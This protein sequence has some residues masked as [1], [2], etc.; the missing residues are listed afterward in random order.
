MTEFDHFKDLIDSFEALLTEELR[1]YRQ[2]VNENIRDFEALLLRFAENWNNVKPQNIVFSDVDAVDS[3]VKLLTAQRTNL[4]DLQKQEQKIQEELEF[5]SMETRK[6]PQIEEVGKEVTQYFDNFNLIA[7]FNEQFEKLFV[8]DW[9]VVRASLFEFEDLINIWTKRLN[10]MREEMLENMETTNTLSNSGFN[11]VFQFLFNEN[12]KNYRDV[13]PILKL[14][15]GENFTTTHWSELLVI[16]SIK[17]KKFKDVTFK[18]LIDCVKVFFEKEKEIRVLYNRAQGE[19]MIRDALQELDSWGTSQTFELAE[20]TNEMLSTNI[21]KDWNDLFTVVS[22]NQALLNSLKE[23][24]Y[25]PNFEAQILFWEAKIEAIVRLLQN[26]NNI[27]RK[28]VYLNPIFLRGSIPKEKKKFKQLNDEI[29]VFFKYFTVNPAIFD[30][31]RFNKLERPDQSLSLSVKSLSERSL[32]IFTFTNNTVKALEVFQKKLFDFLEEKREIFPRFYF[33][34]D[35]DLLEVL[36]QSQNIE[37]LQTHMKKLFSGIS[38]IVVEAEIDEVDNSEQKKIIEIISSTDEH[39]LLNKP[40]WI[41]RGRNTEHLTANLDESGST[42]EGLKTYLPVE[43]W[44]NE[45]E[46]VVS[47]TLKELTYECVQQIDLENYPI[48]SILLSYSVAFTKAVEK[49]ME[50]PDISSRKSKLEKYKEEISIGM[51]QYIAVTETCEPLLRMNIK[52]LIFDLVHQLDILQELIEHPDPTAKCFLWNRQLRFYVDKDKTVYCECCDAKFPY[53]Y[54]YLSHTPK[55]VHTPLTDKLYL[56]LTQGLMFGY[57]GNPVGPAGTGKTE[58]VKQLASIMGLMCIVLNCDEG[59]DYRSMGRIF[60]GLVK[61]GA[62]GCFD[63]FNRLDEEVLSAIS[64]QISAI[65]N[66]IK[67]KSPFTELLGKQ[68]PT[69]PAT[70]IFV[71]MNPLSKEYQGR[72]LLPDNLKALFR[73][74]KMIKPSLHKIIQN[75]L[76]LE[77]Y[78]LEYLPSLTARTVFFF[79][80]VSNQL[81]PQNHYDWGLRSL[82][83]IIAMAGR[84][85]RNRKTKMKQRLLEEDPELANMTDED[86]RDKIQISEQEQSDLIVQAI[87]MSTVAKLTAD[88][89]KTFDQLLRDIFPNVGDEQKLTSNE[90]IEMVLNEYTFDKLGLTKS[91]AQVHKVLQ[92]WN[93]VTQRMGVCIVGPSLSGKTTVWKLLTETLRFCGI[94]CHIDV[95]SPKSMPRQ[96]LLGNMDLDTREWEDGVLTAS[97]RRAQ[98]RIASLS[99]LPF[100]SDVIE[101]LDVEA[102]VL[103]FKDKGE[104]PKSRPTI[105]FCT[106]VIC[107]GDI[108]PEWIES[109]NSVLDD[110][111]LLTLPSGE[112]IK[113]DRSVN[114]LFETES[115]LYASPATVSRM[116]MVFLSELDNDL[117]A[118]ATTLIKEAKDLRNPVELQDWLENILIPVIIDYTKNHE[119]AFMLPCTPGGLMRAIFPHVRNCTDQQEFLVG[120][121]LGL[122]PSLIPEARDDFIKT[123]FQQNKFHTR[124][125]DPQNPLNMS[126][127]TDSRSIEDLAMAWDVNE[128]EPLDV[129]E[130]NCLRRVPTSHM[131]SYENVLLTWLWNEFDKGDDAISSATLLIGQPASGKNTLFGNV[132]SSIKK[133]MKENGRSLHLYTLTCSRFTQTADI[134]EIIKSNTDEVIQG[135]DLILM[136]ARNSQMVIYLKN[137]FQLHFDQYGTSEVNEFLFSLLSLGG[138]YDSKTNEFVHIKNISFVFSSDLGMMGGDSKKLIS[139]RLASC[140]NICYLHFPSKEE[141]EVVGNE[142]IKQSVHMEE[143]FMQQLV[144]AS[145]ELYFRLNK[146]LQDQNTK[147]PDYF[148]FNPRDLISLL[149][150]LDRY[151]LI[152]TDFIVDKMMLEREAKKEGKS[153]EAKQLLADQIKKASNMDK[154]QCL[155]NAWFNESVV[156]FE[157]RLTT[158]M[159][160]HRFLTI[161]TNVFQNRFHSYDV[162]SINEILFTSVA[163]YLKE[164]IV[165]S[166][167]TG[168]V[169][170]QT[171]TQT[172]LANKKLIQ[173]SRGNLKGLLNYY[174]KQ[175]YREV[176]ESPIFVTKELLNIFSKIDRHFCHHKDQSLI[177]LTPPG[178][179]RTTAWSLYCFIKQV[180]LYTP[181]YMRGL[182]LKYFRNELKQQIVTNFIQNNNELIIKLDDNHLH[183]VSIV[184]YISS[185]ISGVSVTKLFNPEELEGVSM[186]LKEEMRNEGY[187]G[188]L[189]N[190]IDERVRKNLKF[191]FCLDFRGNDFSNKVNTFSALY[192]NSAILVLE[193]W[194]DNTLMTLFKQEVFGDLLKKMKEKNVTS[195]IYELIG[196]ENDSVVEIQNDMSALFLSLYHSI[197]TFEKFSQTT[198]FAYESFA[199]TIRVYDAQSKNEESQTF[200]EKVEIPAISPTHFIKCITNMKSLLAKHWVDVED[201]MTRLGLGLSKL[202]ETEVQVG[203]MQKDAAEQSKILSQKQEEAATALEQIKINM[204]LA[205]EQ[206]AAAEKLSTY[207]NGEEAKINAEKEVAEAQLSSI[208]PLI[209]AA[210]EN[211]DCIEPKHLNEIRSFA[212]PPAA[213]QDVLQGVMMMLGFNNLSWKDIKGM[214]NPSIKERIFKFDSR[215]VTPNQLKKIARF[216]ETNDSSFESDNIRRVSQAAAPMAE[217]LKAQV[218]YAKV[219][220]NIKP[221]TDNLAKL[222]ASLEDSRIQLRECQEKIVEADEK[223]AALTE[224]FSKKTGEA[225]RLKVNLEKQTSLLNRAQEL[226][227]KLSGE[228]ARWEKQYQ[229]FELSKSN[230]F[231]S[232]MVSSCYFTYLSQSNLKTRSYFLKMWTEALGFENKMQE[233]FCIQDFLLKEST[234]LSL[235]LLGLLS[236]RLSLENYLSFANTDGVPCLID[237]TGSI[238]AFIVALLENPLED[239]MKPQYDVVSA[240]DTSLLTKLELA[241]RFGKTLILKDV[242]TI[243]TVLTPLLK[244]IVVEQNQR[245]RTLVGEKSIDLHDDFKLILLTQNPK[246]LQTLPDFAKDYITMINFSITFNGLMSQIIEIVVENEQPE[247]QEEKVELLKDEETLKATLAKLENELLQNLQ[248]DKPLLE[249]EELIENLNLMKVKSAEITVSLERCDLVKANLEEQKQVFTNFSKTTSILYFL[250][251]NLFSLNHV[252]QFSLQSFFRLFKNT[253]KEKSG[254]DATGDRA[255]L[256]HARLQFL[257]TVLLT[258]VYNYLSAG[259]FKVDRPLFAF[260]I[261]YGLYSDAFPPNLYDFIT[262]QCIF[263]QTLK[264]SLSKAKIPSF[265]NDSM[266]LQLDKL[267]AV[268]PK[269]SDIWNNIISDQSHWT[270]WMVSQNPEDSGNAFFNN[271]GPVERISIVKILRPDR[272]PISIQKFVFGKL[273]LTSFEPALIDFKLLIERDSYPQQFIIYLVN[274]GMDPSDE[275]KSKLENYWT[276]RGKENF[277]DHFAEVSMG[278]GQQPV[279]LAAIEKMMKNGGFVILKNLHLVVRWIP[280]LQQYFHQCAP[281]SFHPDFRIFVT[282]EPR[283]TIPSSLLDNA[284]KITYEAPPGIRQNLF[285]LY[286]SL[287]T[288]EMLINC[289]PIVSR[290]IFLVC[291]LH[292]LLQ[293]R[294]TYNP[295]GWT[296]TYEFNMSNLKST[297]DTIIHFCDFMLDN[298]KALNKRPT[299]NHTTKISAIPWKTLRG[300]VTESIYGG[301]LDNDQDYYI[302]KAYVENTIDE[303]VLSGEKPFLKSMPHLRVPSSTNISDYQNIIAQLPSND[304]PIMFGLSP[305]VDRFI[306]VTEADRLITGLQTLARGGID[307]GSGDASLNIAGLKTALEPTLRIWNGLRKNNPTNAPSI[308]PVTPLDSLVYQQ[309][310]TSVSLFNLVD[311]DFKQIQKVFDG[312]SVLTAAL[313]NVI[314]YLAKGDVPRAWTKRWWGPEGINKWMDSFIAKATMLKQYVNRIHSHLSGNNDSCGLLTGAVELHAFLQPASFLKALHQTAARG[315]G[316][317]VEELHFRTSWT[318]PDISVYA[319]LTNLYIQGGLFTSKDVTDCL[320]TSAATSSLN[321]CY[322]YFTTDIEEDSN[323][324]QVP[325]YT[326]ITREEYLFNVIMP[327]SVPADKWHLAGLAVLLINKT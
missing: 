202:R 108:D 146:E 287:V 194:S 2:K 136:P 318:Q 26:I 61:C 57:G 255:L 75:L 86:I 29:L 23:S 182:N 278:Q 308:D 244:G 174:I 5:F 31:L 204:A 263:D 322:L 298:P 88:D 141:I 160:K 21:I 284:T 311:G 132:I 259:I 280:D 190:Y 63:E 109:L 10:D 66:S 293:E 153:E 138:F 303:K 189:V 54:E 205:N 69:N 100:A 58:S 183:D 246:L 290:L 149:L 47:E 304:T 236:D 59:I 192:Q 64:T 7:E 3:T 233:P 133:D 50:S 272:L 84:L 157:N 11:S 6:F 274:P 196:E 159:S 310:L 92:V 15:T 282:T 19:V 18:D 83:T 89:L 87:R 13:Y 156:L 224:D 198:N 150:N 286:S 131:L 70:G 212:K 297:V 142:L 114:F 316:V 171:N 317:T 251:K 118:M 210:K 254:A 28:W 313:Q 178:L 306:N 72:S 39:M 228:K 232:V 9:F 257:N 62:W 101:D 158:Q 186:P 177:L 209:Q 135:S 91:P 245:K 217:W 163:Q 206:K 273:G 119:N 134:I 234:I 95:I 269:C 241:V 226:L 144:S 53:G 267:F 320:P 222:S 140:V 36:G 324:I 172:A 243:D 231:L 214:L 32:P 261:T 213:I 152:P 197:G 49:K 124:L 235:N 74:I 239:I 218:E 305:N 22:D 123:L 299:Q 147:Y 256:I 99:H 14:I 115:L 60:T 211:V 223:V 80:V 96:K 122:S 176:S 41:T 33:L 8:Q 173:I 67:N 199:E 128:E 201:Q 281:E 307:V 216:I 165:A 30:V 24:P 302:L 184:E 315:L 268:Y 102:L 125:P 187:N 237:P 262:D 167:T 265:I 103:D 215:S 207:L 130:M 120:L 258:N 249:N 38:K 44:L 34:G 314:G 106:Y 4:N 285:S 219:M 51:S 277:P 65:Q 221:L 151:E 143:N 68:I 180:E 195:S 179:G 181:Y 20:Y 283:G 193:G 319:E 294:R 37:V 242:S 148:S 203:I 82:K 46:K 200:S 43:I 137:F 117:N 116:G 220:V 76:F 325:V 35:D 292:T 270:N 48:Q 289:G 126:Y 321:S 154:K 227:G 175:Y 309:Y 111:A 1:S 121:G 229:A 45:L 155:L 81:S 129:S 79:T 260:Y 248:S 98:K 240:H 164:D 110:N 279:A 42:D 40:V 78:S 105:G 145:V 271:L 127:D 112:R 185:I 94:D 327:S 276:S 12:L 252:Y 107:D 27:Q 238:Q 56:T 52:A 225:E 323:I 139:E 71:T 288:P 312:T 97:G 166:F 301:K 161:L 16:L 188:G 275:I 162:P 264:N 247:L 55:L 25:F 85:M 296:Q 73:E 168:D 191:L 77:N 90:K 104:V 326:D 250:I 295:Q 170:L 300:I 253:L 208:E 113:F 291:F 169:T 230:L 17:N 266:M 93:N